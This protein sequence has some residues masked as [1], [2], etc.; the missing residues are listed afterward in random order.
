MCADGR[1][2]L[3]S[4]LFLALDVADRKS[5][6]TCAALCNMPHTNNTS[7]HVTHRGLATSQ[8]R[9]SSVPRPKGAGFV[10]FQPTAGICDQWISLMIGPAC[11]NYV[12][13]QQTC[14]FSIHA[15]KI[16]VMIKQLAQSTLPLA[17][18]LS[19]KC[20]VIE[21]TQVNRKEQF[22]TIPAVLQAGASAALFTNRKHPGS[23]LNGSPRLMGHFGFNRWCVVVFAL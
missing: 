6:L 19:T 13:T 18:F 3:H 10:V 14:W 7:I 2:T 23:H 12:P 16:W 20:T 22:F 11:T 4:V 15:S 17:A 9:S 5:D 1:H 21:L 8:Q